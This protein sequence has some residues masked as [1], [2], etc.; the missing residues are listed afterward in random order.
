MDAGFSTLYRARRTRLLALLGALA[1]ALLPLPAAASDA[2]LPVLRVLIS[3][4]EQAPFVLREEGHI[5]G[6]ILKELIDRLAQELHLSP[7][8]IPLP[9]K[10]LEQALKSGQVHLLPASS[11]DWL[12]ADLPLYWTNPWLHSRERL[13]LRQDTLAPVNSLNDLYGKRLGTVM[14]HQYP[15]LEFW[16]ERHLILRSDG[17]TTAQNLRRLA[18]GRIEALIDSELVILHLAAQNPDQFVIAPFSASEQYYRMALTPQA[19]CSGAALEEAL[20]RLLQAGVVDA[21]ISPTAH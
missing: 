14:G 2:P 6:G 15:L 3:D 19:P 1:L 5:S 9:R 12:E 18:R 11:P 13:L 20:Q 10:R 21:L 4:H 16:F 17:H 7:L 8:Y